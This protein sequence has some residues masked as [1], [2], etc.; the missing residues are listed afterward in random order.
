MSPDK[1]DRIVRIVRIGAPLALVLVVG[2]AV[3]RLANDTGAQRREVPP[4]PVVALT[5]PPPPPPAPPK[6]PEPQ[7]TV[8]TP[9]PSP[10]PKA[11]SPKVEAPQQLTINGPPQAGG[12][13]FGVAAGSGGGTTIGGDPN[14]SGGVGGDFGEAAYRRFLSTALQQAIQSDDRASRLSFTAQV[15]VW[16]APDGRISNVAVAR[17]SGDTR[18]DRTLIAAL[19]S[20]GRL[21]EPP[22]PNIKFPALVALRGRKA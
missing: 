11:E 16:I 5:P 14:G 18:T 22:P 1:R 10:A 12:D 15:R 19:M 13:S 21:E 17:S 9:V 3:W 2:L 6:P 7:K 8:E 20:A 4:T